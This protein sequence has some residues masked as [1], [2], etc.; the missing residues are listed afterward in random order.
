[1]RLLLV[2]VA[3]FGMAQTALADQQTGIPAPL[4]PTIKCI[5]NVLKSSSAVSA[6]DVYVIDDSRFGFEY[7]FIGTDS[8]PAVSYVELVTLSPDY[9]FLGDK[10]PREVPEHAMMKGVDLT[11][12]LHLAQKCHLREAFDNLFPQPPARVRW[13]RINLPKGFH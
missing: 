3:L 4:L 6:V 11:S 12:S 8:Q 10:I 2:G 7:T 13:R 1:M 5:Y 9:G